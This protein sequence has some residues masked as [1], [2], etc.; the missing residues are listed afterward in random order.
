VFTDPLEVRAKMDE[1][2]REANRVFAVSE[3]KRLTS[4]ERGPHGV[5]FPLPE[6]LKRAPL[7]LRTTFR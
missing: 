5:R 6:W 2:D 1:Y 3:A 7:V 4:I